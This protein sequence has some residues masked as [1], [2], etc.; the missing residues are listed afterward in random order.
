MTKSLNIMVLVT[1]LSTAGGALAGSSDLERFH[2]GSNAIELG[3]SVADI[4]LSCG[5]SWKPA[6]VSKHTR[7][8]VGENE[9]N[10]SHDYF[11]KW[12][13]NVA[14]KSDTHIILKNDEV[15]RIFTVVQ[16]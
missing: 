16:Q 7:A 8:A 5:Q 2:C 14:G 13:Y 4:K 6:Y 12:M 1:L 15:I 11:E 10:Q 9:T 3:M